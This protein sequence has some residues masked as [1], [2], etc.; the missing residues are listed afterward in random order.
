M[1]LT[2]GEGIM[3]EAIHRLMHQ[4]PVTEQLAN[5]ELMVRGKGML[6][7]RPLNMLGL[8]DYSRTL[9]VVRQTFTGMAENPLMSE[10]AW[11]FDLIQRV[12]IPEDAQALG[13]VIMGWTDDVG[14]HYEA[15]VELP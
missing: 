6:P 13:F 14:W 15:V 7:Q 9:E 4:I 2:I 5:A 3:E 12:V 10:M 8:Q 1:V 11:L